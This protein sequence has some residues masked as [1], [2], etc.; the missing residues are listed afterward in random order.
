[1][2]VLIILRMHVHSRGWGRGKAN[3]HKWHTGR[4]AG[5]VG[6]KPAYALLQHKESH[7]HVQGLKVCKS[8]EVGRGVSFKKCKEH[9]NGS[10]QS[11]F[12]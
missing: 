6:S 11:G 7:R 4:F 9:W 5:W 10:E 3:S 1:M 12:Q 2:G 8:K